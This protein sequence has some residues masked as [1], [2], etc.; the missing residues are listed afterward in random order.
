VIKWEKL[1]ICAAI[2]LSCLKSLKYENKLIELLMIGDWK[3]ENLG[4]Q[5][6]MKNF[7]N[8]LKFFSFKDR[9]R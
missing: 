7:Q 4:C 8:Y 6:K 5:S 9:L 2:Q 3:D 1:L